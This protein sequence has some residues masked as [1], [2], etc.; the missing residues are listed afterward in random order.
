MTD[1]PAGDVE[2][3]VAPVRL[4]RP[5]LD[6]VLDR[7]Q[8]DVGQ[9]DPQR[10]ALWGNVRLLLQRSQYARQFSLGSLLRR[11]AAPPG[12]LPLTIDPDVNDEEPGPV[13]GLPN[14]AAAS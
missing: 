1:G 6:G 9:E 10:L 8:P 11:E 2:P 5:W 13:G 14:A 4:E 7:R 3:H 12:L